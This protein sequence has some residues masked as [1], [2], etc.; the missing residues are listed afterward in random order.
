MH[1]V[2]ILSYLFTHYARFM[3]P[4]VYA[5]CS[6]TINFSNRSSRTGK[7]QKWHRPS[8]LKTSPTFTARLLDAIAV[9]LLDTEVT[10]YSSQLAEGSRN[11]SIK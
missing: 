5:K 8:R 11:E 7:V 3:L 9:L 2:S 1:R 10:A 4:A 6:V